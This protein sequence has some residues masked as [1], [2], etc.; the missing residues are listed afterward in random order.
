[1]RIYSVIEFAPNYFPFL[2]IGQYWHVNA[3]HFSL[4]YI[5]ELH[6]LFVLP[7]FL[8][9]QYALVVSL[10]LPNDFSPSF[11]RALQ[12]VHFVVFDSPFVHFEHLLYWIHIAYFEHKH[13]CV[14]FQ[15][16]SLC[17]FDTSPLPFPSTI[18][19]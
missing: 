14:S 16:L 4:K 3:L 15:L 5:P 8:T 12:S 18:A 1:M 6:L 17:Q 10:L 19:S 11:C 13:H 7:W 2:L 9:N